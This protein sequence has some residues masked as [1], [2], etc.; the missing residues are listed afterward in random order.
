MSFGIVLMFGIC[1]LANPKGDDGAVEKV[2]KGDVMPA[3]E[4]TSETIN[5]SSEALKGKVVLINFFATW[6]P[7]C[8]KELPHLQQ[9]VWEKF[10]NNK[11]FELL[12]IGREHDEK[13][14]EAFKKKKQFD[15]PF[16]PDKER[17]VFSKFAASSIPRNYLINKEGVIVYASSGFNEEA[18]SEMLKVLEKLLE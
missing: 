14:L 4:I 9:K 7:P 8:Q 15:L 16:Y 13:E 5:L 11:D 17:H 12:V 1:A 2:K 6:C 10:K 18:F 3:F